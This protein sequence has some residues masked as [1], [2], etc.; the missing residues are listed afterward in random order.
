MY[1][2]HCLLSHMLYI[3]SVRVCIGHRFLNNALPRKVSTVPYTY[4]IKMIIED[5]L[6]LV[7]GIISSK[8][9]AFTILNVLVI[10]Q[11]REQNLS[12][13]QNLK[14]IELIPTILTVTTY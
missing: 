5:V 12:D 9:F 6:N 1:Q 10:T 11:K 13:V 3:I 8:S 4:T 2:L 14:W 7:E